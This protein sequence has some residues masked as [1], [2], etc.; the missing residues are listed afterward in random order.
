MARQSSISSYL[1]ERC[2]GGSVSLDSPS[3]AQ[4]LFEGVPESDSTIFSG[5]V[6]VDVKVS[7]ALKV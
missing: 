3:L 1:I 7:L 4:S 2:I 5:V 6:V